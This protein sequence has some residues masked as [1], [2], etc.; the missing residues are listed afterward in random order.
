MKNIILIFS[1]LSMLFTS[2][3]SDNE[4]ENIYI[5]KDKEWLDENI[6]GAWEVTHLWNG[7]SGIWAGTDWGYSD[8]KITFNPDKTV[9]IENLDIDNGTLNYNIVSEDYTTFIVINNVKRMVFSLN[10]NNKTL[11][12]YNYAKLKKQ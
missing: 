5:D 7:I 11:T 1:I 12:L 3:S 6:I 8:A 10:M 2:C 4:R 9:K